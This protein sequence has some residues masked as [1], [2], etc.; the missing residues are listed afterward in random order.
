MKKK[1]LSL[2]LVIALFAIM[3]GGTL[4]Y[5][6]AEDEVTNTFTVGSVKIEIYENDIATENDAYP[7]GPLVPVVNTTNPAEDDSYHAKSVEVK[8]TGLNDA[9]VRTHIAIPS[10]LVGYLYLDLNEAGWTR[11]QDSTATVEGVDYVVFTYDYNEKLAP[12]AF[13]TELLKGAYLGSNVDL[14]EDETTGNLEFILRDN[15][16][17]VTHTSGFDAHTKTASGYESAEVNILV[18]SQAIQAQGFD[19]ATSTDALNSGFAAN[20]WAAAN[21]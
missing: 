9:Y 13:T 16:G 18:A 2:A 8:N 15:A 14:Q 10:K 21:P 12:N 11:Q 20:P 4:A 3:V 19:N 7:F 1:I 17:K 6:S 5:F